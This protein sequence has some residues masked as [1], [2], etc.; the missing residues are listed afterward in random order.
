MSIL[1]IKSINQKQTISLIFLISLSGFL[2]RLYFY[3]Y[4][5]PVSL[6]ALDNF[7]YSMALARGDIFP[8]GYITN[9]FG[10]PIFLSPFLAISWSHEMIDFM[11]IQRILSIIIS[12]STIIPLYYL[13][14]NFFKKEIAIISSSLVVLS[15]KIIENSLLGIGDPLF[16]FLIIMSIMF[17]FIKDSKF[18]ILSYIFGSFGFIVRQEGILILIPLILVFVI[19]KNFDSKNFLKLGIGVFLFFAIIQTADIILLNDVKDTSIFDTVIHAMNISEQEIIIKDDSVNEIGTITDN[20]F[21]FLKNALTTYFMLSGWT[22]FPNLIFFVILSIIV[23][24]KKISKNRAIFLL[25]LIFLSLTSL[26]AYGKGIQ[27]VRYLF[28]LIPIFGI[29]SCYGLN[30]I[31]LKIHKKLFLLLIPFVLFSGLIVE[32]TMHENLLQKES[33]E[34]AKIVLQYNATGIND[35]EQSKFVK[36]AALFYNWPNLLPYGETRSVDPGVEKFPTADY[37]DINE[38]ISQNQ[39]EGLSHIVVYEKNNRLFL[40]EL[41]LNEN[42]SS[43]LKKIYDSGD[44]GHTNRLKVFQIDYEEFQ[45]GL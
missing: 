44:F 19:K 15:P 27:E 34:D 14:K 28:P 42:K 10:W 30:V 31:F 26:F 13:T 41:Y 22:L 24:R 45:S 20:K 2:I 8:D 38:Y 43:F 5:I 4:D 33:F 12:V 9:K 21:Q 37:T 18:Y 23:I 29:F 32:F 40:D 39:N 6:D 1:Q 17:V 16:L 25:F 36:S 7:L 3:P 11:N 35:Y